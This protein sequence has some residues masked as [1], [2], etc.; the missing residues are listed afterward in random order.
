MLIKTR[1]GL[2]HILR[3]YPVHN[4]LNLLQLKTL[5]SKVIESHLRRDLEDVSLFLDLATSAPKISGLSDPNIGSHVRLALSYRVNFQE[6]NK[7]ISV[8]EVHKTLENIP[9]QWDPYGRYTLTPEQIA[10]AK[11]ALDTAESIQ[12]FNEWFEH[13]VKMYS[14]SEWSLDQEGLLQEKTVLSSI[15]DDEGVK[16]VLL[17]KVLDLQFN[18]NMLVSATASIRNQICEG[19][20][21]EGQGF[22]TIYAQALEKHAGFFKEPQKQDADLKKLFGLDVDKAGRDREFGIFFEIGFY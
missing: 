20:L 15:L 17:Q 1:Y 11:S 13:T 9:S 12:A 2:F 21:S 16:K 6:R 18:S 7:Q 19:C 14:G 3:Y 4:L 5:L 10:S 8:D 22:D